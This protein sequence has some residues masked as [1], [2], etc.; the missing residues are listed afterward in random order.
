MSNR[1]AELEIRGPRNRDEVNF[2]NELMAKTHGP[3]YWEALRKVQTHAGYPNYRPEF[4]R[5]AYWEGELAGTLRVTSDTIRLGEARLHMGG[6]GWVS[7]AE[8]HRHKG[9]AR[10]L[11]ADTMNFLQARGYHVA[12]LFGIPNFYHRFG[13]ATALG[14]YETG[15][16]TE[17]AMAA[18][19]AQYRM[20]TVKPGDIPAIQ[21]L[22]NLNDAATACS[23]VRIAPHISLRWDRWKD[24]RVLTDE[25]GKV[26]GYLVPRRTGEGLLIDETGVAERGACGALLHASAC[27]AAEEIA[28]EIR[29][30]APPEHPLMQY[31]LQF[32]S[33][34]ETHITRDEG[35]MLAFVNTSEA[36][37]SMAPEWESQLAASAVRSLRVEA[38]L[39]V[40]RVPYRVRANKGAIDVSV[41]VGA[42][43]VG[44]SQAELMHLVTG[45]RFLDDVLAQRRRMLSP[46]AR[47]LLAALFPKRTPYVWLLDRF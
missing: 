38:T 32:R 44:L 33:C 6:L 26:F 40:D 7:T 31:L 8:T 23:L 43:K 46:E 21:R 4:T 1:P 15:V 45:Y 18:P 25:R 5:L 39:M 9:I 14:Q 47:L 27:V 41:A 2:A 12:M 10:E 20:R 3:N 37:E 22:H 17:E 36:L 19:H 35:G 34:H 30:H 13:F 16:S 28:Q 29:F 42:N 24:A 11:L